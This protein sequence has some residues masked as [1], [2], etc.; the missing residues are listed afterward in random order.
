MVNTREEI[1]NMLSYIP[2]DD[3]D[4]WVHMAFAVKS[5][6]GDDGMD[7]WMQ[8]S[9]TSEKFNFPS[10]ISTWRSARAEGGVTAGT[11]YALAKEH[12]F[13]YNG[14]GTYVP[15]PV[16]QR[17]DDA[18]IKRQIQEEEQKR[19]QA[20]Q[21]AAEILAA[22]IL[23]PHPYLAR[24]GF[25]NF[26][27]PQDVTTGALLCPMRHYVTNDLQ[28]VQGI[29]AAGEKK[30]LPGGKASEAVYRIGKHSSPE[31]WYVEGI[32]TGLSVWHALE[33]L[34]RQ[35]MSMVVVCYSAGNMKKVASKINRGIIVA[36]NDASGTGINYAHATGLPYWYP[37]DVGKDA[38]D[39]HLEHGLQ[40]LAQELLRT[41]KQ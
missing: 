26:V 23:S 31:I 33:C 11:L 5:A 25:P 40:P 38:N 12:G 17:P 7:I 41:L 6:L 1:A 14:D 2:S 35:T 28:S 36:D 32:A 22:A 30:F 9:R 8:W 10:A 24:K 20:A 18:K 27:M 39:F 13:V 16:I 15:P 4:T 21:R 37:P 29:T 3:R 34:Y 19:Q